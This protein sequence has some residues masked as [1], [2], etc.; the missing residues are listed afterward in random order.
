MGLPWWS[1]VQDAVL[2]KQGVWFQALVKK[3]RSH[4][5]QGQKKKKNPETSKKQNLN[6]LHP[7]IYFHS[8]YIVHTA[9]S[10]VLTSDYML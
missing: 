4:M 9:I 2:P 6:L 1:S 3:L 8:V 7:S 10:Q 5:L